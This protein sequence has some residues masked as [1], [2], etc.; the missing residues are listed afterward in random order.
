MSAMGFVW[1]LADFNATTKS[2]ENRQVQLIQS[3][4][5]GT[6]ADHHAGHMPPHLKDRSIGA[7]KG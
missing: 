6:L 2:P 3:A 7:G 1:V 4:P 5:S